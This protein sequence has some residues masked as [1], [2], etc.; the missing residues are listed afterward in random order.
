MSWFVM[1]HFELVISFHNTFRLDSESVRIVAQCYSGNEA[2]EVELLTECL[3]WNTIR[4]IRECW[5][6]GDVK[7][8][9]RAPCSST[10]LNLSCDEMTHRARKVEQA[11]LSTLQSLFPRLEL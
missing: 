5:I 7:H 8:L 6:D 11:Y 1:I 10:E 3:F 9:V 2:F 4:S